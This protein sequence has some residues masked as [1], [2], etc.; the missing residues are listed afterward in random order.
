MMRRYLLLI[1]LPTLLL[2]CLREDPLVGPVTTEVTKG[3]RWNLRIGSTPEE[4]YADLQVLGIEKSIHQVAVVGQLPFAT[5]QLLNN[6]L[7]LYDALSLQTTSGRS[8]RVLFQFAD[9]TVSYVYAGGGM[10]ESVSRWPEE[11]A[12]EAAIAAG[13]PISDIKRKLIDL[14]RS[15]DYAAYELVLSDK[16][17]GRA[18]DPVMEHFSEWSFTFFERVA[19]PYEDSYTVR[20]IFDNSR[21]DAIRVT[22]QRFETVH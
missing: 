17:L 21:L 4:V 5:P 22:Q 18:Y 6:R 1:L 7:D 15:P 14:Y 2:S 8:D 3:S 16:P 11:V 20:L 10:L 12:E 9:D 13:N 19:P